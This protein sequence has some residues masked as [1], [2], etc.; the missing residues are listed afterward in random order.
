MSFSESLNNQFNNAI[1]TFLQTTHSSRASVEIVN[2]LRTDTSGRYTD[3]NRN[4][5][6]KN[7]AEDV[8]NNIR[9]SAN[10]MFRTPGILH[11]AL[12]TLLDEYLNWQDG[13]LYKSTSSDM[14]VN[15]TEVLVM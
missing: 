2:C 7:L 13:I 12:Q 14:S 8:E 4:V 3:M 5:I 1:V 15:S 10:L 6:V 9:C 11:D